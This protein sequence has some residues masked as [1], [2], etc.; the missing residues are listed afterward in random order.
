MATDEVL[1]H[2]ALSGQVSLRFYG[3]SEATLSLGYFQPAAV[4]DNDS[5]LRQLPF[6][7]RPTGG[8]TL[9]HHH[10]L[11]YALAL[12]AGRSW[13]HGESWLLRMHTIIAAALRELG[14]VVG[15]AEE[16]TPSTHQVLCF[17]QFTR[18]DLLCGGAK[19]VGSAQRKHRQCLLQHGAVLLAASPHTPILPGIRE[20]GES[21][22]EVHETAAAITR[23][24]ATA[25]GCS[26]VPEEWSESEVLAIN[27]LAIG[28][29]SQDVWN[30][31]R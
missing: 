21:L 22:L 28:K 26:M 5:Q 19:V 14:V 29:Y 4:R 2:S 9:V 13:Q 8:A 18:G 11:T 31:K 27:E 1:L 10:E 23:Q 7:R 15:V 16:G 17:Q 24:F 30:R 25:T 3:W 20:R 6:V 12:P